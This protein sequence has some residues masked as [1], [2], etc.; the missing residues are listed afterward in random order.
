VVLRFS[1]VFF[2]FF[3]EGSVLV[4]PEEEEEE[5]E[6]EKGVGLGLRGLVGWLV[7][8]LVGC[9]ASVA[10]EGARAPADDDALQ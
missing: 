4:L 10:A 1:V 7:G 6:E 2:F 3:F 5:E 8:W 9:D